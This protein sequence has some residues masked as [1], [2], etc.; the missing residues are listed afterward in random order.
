MCG[1]MGKAARDKSIAPTAC[2]CS[3]DLPCISRHALERTHQCCESGVRQMFV[4]TPSAKTSPSHIWIL[5]PDCQK[6]GNQGEGQ[7]RYGYIV[8]HEALDHTVT[9]RAAH[10]RGQ[11]LQTDIHGKP[12]RFVGRVAG[13]VVAQPLDFSWQ[14]QRRPTSRRSGR[15][16]SAARKDF[17]GRS[18]RHAFLAGST[19]RRLSDA[20]FRP[21]GHRVFLRA[22]V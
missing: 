13:T 2:R 21:D 19:G 3:V 22:G 15:I 6:R 1:V 10:G 16:V 8:F 11:W 12:A 5:F 7:K 20:G 17:C 4:M 18:A 14:R 9:L